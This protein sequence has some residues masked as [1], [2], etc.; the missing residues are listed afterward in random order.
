MLSYF[1]LDNGLRVIIDDA[2]SANVV[3]AGIAVAAGTRY[4]LPHEAGMA[5][6]VEHMTFK[7]TPRLTSLQIL[8]R[9][10]SVG[11]DLNAYTGKEE[12]VYYS[13][14]PRQHLSRALSLLTDITFNSLYPQAELEKERE[15]VIDEIESYNDSPSDL[16]YDDFE[17]LLY[18]D[19][20]LGRRILGDA[21]SLRSY[22][23]AD[24][25]RFVRRLYTPD[26][27]ILFVKGQVTEKEVRRCL[28]HTAAPSTPTPGLTHP[29]QRSSASVAQDGFTFSQTDISFATRQGGGI[30]YPLEYQA[31]TSP[32]IIHK[33][34]HQA[35]VMMGTSAYGL[36]DERYIGLALLNNL[37]GGPAMNSRL[38]LA[39]REHSGL[40]YAVESSLSAYTDTSTWAVY[41][42]CD[43][44][45]VRRCLRL[46]HRELRRLI[47]KPL[48]PRALAAAKRQLCG[49]MSVAT[50]SFENN[51]LGMAKRYL[52]T[53]HVPTLE[54][55]CEHINAL[56]ADDLQA[57]AA[58]IFE[59]SRL[60]T[61]IYE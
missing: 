47:D 60:L 28:N 15:V 5:H 53:Q 50:D 3:Y 48:T 24:L 37:L 32:F 36:T 19:H 59:P 7:G 12:V 18:R 16:I 56:R 22:A 61:V 11:G 13:T 17:A 6:F 1:Q 27:A 38:S 57:I 21:D 8:N 14:F 40:V 52:L 29:Q 51:A 39:L 33:S 54:Q 46:V 9:M 26:R 20:P 2:A 34:T 25:Q 35:H 41:F 31:P 23:T 43:H 42:G 30:A 44:A 55:Q 10:E 58:D 49:Q 45:D 4:E